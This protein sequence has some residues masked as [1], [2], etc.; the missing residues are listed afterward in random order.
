[1]TNP[2]TWRS[3]VGF[4]VL[5]WAAA[6]LFHSVA[7]WSELDGQKPL[8]FLLYSKGVHYALWTLALP[9]L[10]KC[11]KRFPV[12]HAAGLRNGTA[13]LLIV[14]GLA[15][16]VSL[17]WPA[18]IYSTWFPYRSSFPTLSSFVAGYF[19]KSLQGDLLICVALVIVLQGWRVWQDLQAARTRATELERQLAVSRL[20]ALRMQLHPHFLFNSLHTIASLIGDQPGTARRMVVALGD[21]LR[22]TLKEGSGPVRSLAEELEFTDLYMG[23]E[24]LRLGERLILDYDIE[25]EATKAEIPQ[26]LLQPLFENAVRH[27]ASRVNGTCKIAFRAHRENGRLNLSLEN[28]GPEISAPVGALKNGVGL[29]NTTARLRLHYGENFTLQYTDR[30]RGGGARVELSVPYRRVGRVPETS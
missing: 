5:G 10:V 16:L 9:L 11:V 7:M 18:I 13:L 21:F 28:D 29:T 19:V 23:I 6:T 1:M 25:P 8:G 24:K 3:G 26:L 14:L 12:P 20:D 30:S 27:G 22:L 2:K 4:A 17:T 15:P